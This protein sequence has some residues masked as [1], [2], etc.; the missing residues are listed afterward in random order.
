MR[1]Q[2]IDLLRIVLMVMVVIFHFVSFGN[3]NFNDPV[4]LNEPNFLQSHFLASFTV[5][6]VNCY[7]MI[8][9][10]VRIRPCPGKLALILIPVCFYD[11]IIGS[12]F[13]IS[14]HG[15]R[16][17]DILF[18]IPN[19]ITET[20]WFVETYIVLFLISP[21]LNRMLNHLTMRSH[22]SIILLGCFLFY[23]LPMS[24]FFDLTRGDRGF[25]I[26]NF[27]MLYVT[28]DC[29]RRIHLEPGN[30]IIS[31]KSVFYTAFTCYIAFSL[32]TF[33][34]NALW[35]GGRHPEDGI[36]SPFYGYNTFTVYL[37]AICLFV[38]FLNHDIKNGPA[39]YFIRIAAPLTF[40][41]YIIHEQPDIRTRVYDWFSWYE[42]QSP[43]WLFLV[44]L[45]SIM[46][47]AAFTFVEWV[48]RFLFGSFDSRIERFV[49]KLYVKIKSKVL[50]IPGT[51]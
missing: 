23:V 12:F 25:G 14:Q 6:A 21:F 42:N 8:S 37:A 44:P 15:L 31:R 46:I 2:G 16:V 49:I 30:V 27:V 51:R 17:S 36:Q 50:P 39:R 34:I 47:F 13:S 24:T 1:N 5:V 33:L 41:V 35:A 9:G 11:V 7:V 3:L 4:K 43:M 10:Y 28:G 20:Y 19:S 26:E 40:P 48:R 38:I 18:R 29:L 45:S 22:V 32:T